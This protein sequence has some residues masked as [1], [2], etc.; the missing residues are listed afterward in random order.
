M[1]VNILHLG[2]VEGQFYLWGEKSP[3]GD[4]ET[5]RK[6]RRKSRLS[7]PELPFGTAVAD[8]I[9]GLSA[10]NV[11][12]HFK[13]NES[14]DM[15]VWLPTRSDMPSASSILIA[16]VPP[17]R[18]K[19]AFAPWSVTAIRLSV[20]DTIDLLCAAIDKPTLAPG[21]IAGA[22]V[23]Y[24]SIAI[25][26]AT[27]LVAGQ[28]YLPGMREV[29]DGYIAEWAPVID[30]QDAAH[31]LE[32]ARQMPGVARAMTSI[33]ASELPAESAEKILHRF[34]ARVADALIRS[35]VQ[36]SEQRPFLP[37]KSSKKRRA[38]DSVHDAWLAALQTADATIEG[39]LRELKDLAG[40]IANWQRPVRM[41]GAAPVRLCFRLEEPELAVDDS[42]SIAPARKIKNKRPDPWQ[43][44]YLLQARN[45]PSLLVPVEKMWKGHRGKTSTMK[46]L[47]PGTH[48]YL[49]SSL[50]QAA[51]I[52]PRIERSLKSIKPTGYEID[53]AG[54]F[55]FLTQKAAALQQAG[56]AV[57]LPA[58]WT[59][60]GTKLKL[61]AKAKLSSPK[62]TGNGALSMDQLVRFEWQVAL[63]DEVLSEQELAALASLKQPLVNIRGQWVQLSPEEIQAAI[64]VWK[65]KAENTATVREVVQLALGATDG[66][67]TMTVAGVEA[68]GWIGQLLDQLQGKAEFMEC[69]PSAAF[70]GQLRPYQVR[71]YSWLAFLRRWGLGAC[72]ADDMGLGKTVQT[73]ALIQREWNSGGHR[74]VLLICPTSVVGNWQK[75]AARF[76]PDLPVMVHHGITRAKDTAFKKQASRHAIVISS[77]ALLHRDFEHLAKMDWAGV[78]LDEAQ[79]IKNPET[80]Q[81]KAAR[82]LRADYRI[83]LTGT[84]VENHVGDLWS[85]MQFLNPG[86]LGTQAEFKRSFFIPIQAQRNAEAT[87]RLKQ[88]TGP[89]LLRR[90]KTDKSIIADLPDKIEMKVFCN[91]TKE[92]ASLYAAVLKEAEISLND[93][94]GIKRK[95]LIL[96][97]LSKLKQVCNHPVHFLGDNSSIP[98]RSGK[99]AR[100]T[101]MIEEL[102]EAGDRTLVFTQFTEM[103]GILHRYLQENFG[104]E[105]L[106]LHGGVTK[107]KR[108]EMVERFQSA[109]GPELLLLSLKAGG[110]GLNLTRANH[111]FHFDRW[112]NP[113]VENQATDRAFRIGQTR[114]VQ[115]HKFICVGTFEERIDEMI[116]SKKE[117]S[118]KVVG[119]GE[120]WL[121]ELSN[122]QLR[123]LFAL[124]KEAVGV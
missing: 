81:A 17:G 63:G 55:E 51:G 114:N 115:V 106:F 120:G 76:T 12:H 93:S 36:C 25:R 109:D 89:F 79:N 78:I 49:L 99:L 80:K 34:I 56:F 103:G 118:D 15:A 119:A 95:G 7:L 88:I 60:K 101:E 87:E 73:L 97:M 91:L 19:F 96:G 20:L 124:R 35:A 9:D 65:R 77:Y 22:D 50:G 42:G 112:W 75:E 100:L 72:L 74:P 84:P 41:A 21:L 90:L 61:T 44:H 6:Q 29:G 105:V 1:A 26:I 39:D 98:D 121:T 30:G 64:D 102:L 83:A 33:K 57:L 27:G 24:W 123:D 38:F 59:G 85:I 40:Q 69:K 94:E 23:A 66:N 92:Q 86:L 113:A 32:L 8:L 52:C 10:A 110:T 107:R 47:G 58:W 117:I 53:A 4:S 13:K 46:M 31:A 67:R 116:E 28:Q 68:D 70:S 5:L 108:D 11:N 122:K 82:A 71:G 54:A 18:S 111:V 14:L 43:V 45:D 3:N 2:I 16:E 37:N 48:E 104:R 62:L